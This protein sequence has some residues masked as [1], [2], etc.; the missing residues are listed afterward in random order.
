MMEHEG[1]NVR[2]RHAEYT[3]LHAI[4]QY[5]LYDLHC[6]AALLGAVDTAVIGM[7][8]MLRPLQGYLWAQ[9]CLIPV[10]ALGF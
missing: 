10:L 4:V 6:N 1:G 2:V 7:M 8:G 9:T 5:S 3:L